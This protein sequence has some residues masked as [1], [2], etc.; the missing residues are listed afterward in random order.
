[1]ERHGREYGGHES[2]I[3]LFDGVS[4]DSG[5]STAVICND[6]SITYGELSLLSGKI[7][8][9]LSGKGAGGGTKVG[10][11]LERSINMMAAVL[12]VLK[13]GAAYIP[14]DPSFP[15]ERL[16]YMIESSDLTFISDR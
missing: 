6:Q 12:G 9:Y 8:G 7:A 14:L 1:M 4:R 13:T 11:C 15:K 10:I 5:G 3:E 2:F 16:T